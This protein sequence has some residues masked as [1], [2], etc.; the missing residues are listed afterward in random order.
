[1]LGQPVAGE[2]KIE[3]AILRYK[4]GHPPFKNYF[5]IG[6]HGYHSPVDPFADDDGQEGRVSS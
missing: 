3:T 5:S 4:A 2:A 6:S 1:M